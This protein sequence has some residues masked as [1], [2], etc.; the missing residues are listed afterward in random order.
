MTTELRPTCQSYQSLCVRL[1]QIADQGP[2]AVDKRLAELESEW[3]S[4]RMVKA[5][6]GVLLAAGLALTA[7]VSPWWLILV[8]VTGVGLLQYLFWPRSW[9][10]GLYWH[11]GF[12]SGS[13]IEDERIALRV[14]RGDFRHLPTISHVEDRDAVTRMEGEGGPACE[15]EDD[16]LDAREAAALIVDR[17]MPRRTRLTTA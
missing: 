5:T 9:L 12:R 11:C 15:V 16:K 4:G 13:D 8:A 7:W 6:T 2:A 3:T 14:L 10:G 1:T 17:T